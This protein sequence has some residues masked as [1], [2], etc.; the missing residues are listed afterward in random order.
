MFGSDELLIHVL[1]IPIPH[2]I[3][4]QTPFKTICLR[5][6]MFIDFIN[7]FIN[8]LSPPK[9]YPVY[10]QSNISIFILQIFRSAIKSL[11]NSA[12]KCQ[13]KY[14]NKCPRMCVTKLSVSSA[15]TYPGS[16]ASKCLKLPAVLYPGS[17]VTSSVHRPFIAKFVRA[18]TPMEHPLPPFRTVMVV[19]QLILSRRELFRVLLPYLHT[20]KTV[21]SSIVLYGW[22]QD[23]YLIIS[24]F[25]FVV[26]LELNLNWISLPWVNICHIC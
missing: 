14:V 5:Q 4:P 15:V 12:I 1:V 8:D 16:S 13:E 22:I 17:S 3:F 24:I 21:G 19:R 25:L 20:V 9:D 2:V 23:L 7:E 10:R 18:A 11:E 6:C 26:I